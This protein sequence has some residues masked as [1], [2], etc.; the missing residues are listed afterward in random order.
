[1]T[2][3]FHQ[4]GGSKHFALELARFFFWFAKLYKFVWSSRFNY[5][6]E[7]L[8]VCYT[9]SLLLRYCN[10]E[11]W[12]IL[13]KLMNVQSFK[14]KESDRNRFERLGKFETIS[15]RKNDD[16]MAVLLMIKIASDFVFHFFL[17]IFS[18]QTV[19]LVHEEEVNDQRRSRRERIKWLIGNRWRISSSISLLCFV[20]CCPLDNNT[21]IL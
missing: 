5:R 4:E 3:A 15:V 8:V 13:I 2:D 9:L 6:I 14:W 20:S 1:M 18:D 17:I 11:I 10:I 16:N 7:F 21:E 19:I 12:K